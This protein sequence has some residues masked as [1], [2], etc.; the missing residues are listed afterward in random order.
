MKRVTN[1]DILQINSLYFQYKNYAEVARQTGFSA[2]T[3]KKY[4]VPGWKPVAAENVKRFSLSEL[5]ELDFSFFAGVKN[6][7]EL[8]ILSE[9]ENCEMEELWKEL[10]I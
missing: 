7:G 10:T 4:V 5:P 6:Y 1:E 2:G 3:V 8:C 9:Q